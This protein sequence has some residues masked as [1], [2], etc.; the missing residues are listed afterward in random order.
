MIGPQDAGAQRVPDRA[1][2]LKQRVFALVRA[3]PK[4]EVGVRV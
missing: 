3:E 4:D 1:R 2:D